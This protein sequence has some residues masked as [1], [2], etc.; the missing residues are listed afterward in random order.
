VTTLRFGAA[1]A[2]PMASSSTRVLANLVRSEVAKWAPLIRST[3][4]VGE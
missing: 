3:W 2:A 1:L 4:V